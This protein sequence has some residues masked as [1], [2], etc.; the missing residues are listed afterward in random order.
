M[1]IFPVPD[2]DLSIAKGDGTLKEYEFGK[3]RITHMV[4]A[5]SIFLT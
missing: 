4:N 3:K 5:F 1:W 2:E